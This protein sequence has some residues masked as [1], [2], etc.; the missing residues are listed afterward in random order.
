VRDKNCDAP[1]INKQ[2]IAGLNSR[3]AKSL[4][5][6]GT[7][8]TSLDTF[9]CAIFFVFGGAFQVVRFNRFSRMLHVMG[10]LVKTGCGVE[11][12]GRQAGTSIIMLT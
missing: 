8:D 11:D 6:L 7:H 1:P 5:A 12:T 2:P 10:R 4:E 9:I 3:R